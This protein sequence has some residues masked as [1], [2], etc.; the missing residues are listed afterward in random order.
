MVLQRGP[1]VARVWGTCSTV[2]EPPNVTIGGKT[3]TSQWD[4]ATA[5]AAFVAAVGPLDV[6]TE[7]LTITVRQGNLSVTLSDVLT[8]DVFLVGRPT[9]LVRK[10]LL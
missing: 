1:A 8:G 3:Y 7:A 5:P 4:P 9:C 6:S 2:L 10:H